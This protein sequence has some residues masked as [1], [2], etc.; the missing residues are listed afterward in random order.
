M[1][2]K[3]YAPLIWSRS[4]TVYTREAYSYD[5]C[6]NPFW[7]S[8]CSKNS[9][10]NL[11]KSKVRE[12]VSKKT[13]QR[14]RRCINFIV[15]TTEL[16]HLWSEKDK[17]FYWYKLG[18]LTL[19][20]PAKQ[21]HTDN[22]ITSKCLKTFLDNLRKTYGLK[23]Y[24]WRAESQKNG[25]IHYHIIL[26]KYI[27]WEQLRTLWNKV[28]NSHGYIELFAQKFNH[29]NPPTVDIRAIKRMKKIA[30][31]LS[32]YCAKKS[33]HRE[34][35]S[36]VWGCSNTLMGYKGAKITSHDLNFNEVH[37][38]VERLSQFTKQI[39]STTCFYGDFSKVCLN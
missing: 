38:R 10:E 34:I 22:F 11:S 25:N 39:E 16:K 24:F 8:G 29:T 3:E 19:T 7:R 12:K 37:E 9:I 13:Q 32:E 15:D 18:F 1:S 35:T 26:D 23:N 36:R 20:L 6:E 33:K 4:L 17:K 28:L 31:Y 27:H 21:F 30:A 2:K 14:I 5:V